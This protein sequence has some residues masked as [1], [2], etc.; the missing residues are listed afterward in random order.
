V[1]RT[2]SHPGNIEQRKNYLRI[3]L[4][5][6]GEYHYFNVPR[7]GRDRRRAEKKASEE[8]DRLQRPYE[9]GISG[10]VRFSDLLRQFEAEE[11]PTNMP[12]GGGGRRPRGRKPKRRARD[13]NPEVLS[14]AGFQDRC[15]SR[16]ANPPRP[17]TANTCGATAQL[18]GTETGQVP[19]S[20]GLREPS[21]SSVSTRTTAAGSS[22]T[23]PRHRPSKAVMP[24][25]P[26][27][28]HYR[29]RPRAGSSP[30]ASDRQRGR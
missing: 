22:G 2:K 14:D 7:T 19:R 18:T 25:E 16:S 6:A 30:P 5:V 10:E 20:S 9:R 27:Q 12:R 21:R 29:A 4:C 26:G 3:R 15:I 17:T 11:L 28:L 13:S 23:G 1:A 24:G 8:Y